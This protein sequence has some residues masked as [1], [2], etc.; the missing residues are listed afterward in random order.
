MKKTVSN[1]QTVEDDN[2]TGKVS[3]IWLLSSNTGS[4]VGSLA[5][6]R[7]FDEFGFQYGTLIE[8][9]ILLLCMLLLT[10]FAMIQMMK[11]VR[12]S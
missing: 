2:C 8:A 10:L 6:A 12:K 11:C 9:I 1:A 5:G 7:A 4:F 3:S